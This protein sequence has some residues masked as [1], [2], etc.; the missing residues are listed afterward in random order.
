MGSSSPGT[1]VGESR[2]PTVSACAQIIWRIFDNSL[3]STLINLGFLRTEAPAVE[4][5]QPVSGNGARYP[6]TALITSVFNY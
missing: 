6:H 3:L 4:L 1:I 2:P 5:S